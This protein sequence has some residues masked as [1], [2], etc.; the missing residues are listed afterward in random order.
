MLSRALASYSASHARSRHNADIYG[1]SFHFACLPKTLQADIVRTLK[2]EAE[3][4]DA[5]AAEDVDSKERNIMDIDASQDASIAVVISDS[6]EE[7]D[8]HTKTSRSATKPAEVKPGAA[9]KQTRKA[10]NGQTIRLYKKEEQITESLSIEQCPMCARPH[11]T[12]CFKCQHTQEPSEL[13]NAASKQPQDSQEAQAQQGQTGL[14][15]SDP[16]AAESNAS[17]ATSPPKTE[18]DVAAN[19]VMQG[20][21]QEEAENAVDSLLFRCNTCKRPAHYTCMPNL[22]ADDDDDDDDASQVNKSNASAGEL[23]LKLDEIALSYQ[24]E[25][26]CDDCLRWDAKPDVILAWRPLGH[27]DLTPEQIQAIPHPSP[28]DPLASVEYYVKW[29]NM[30]YRMAEW[31][32]HAFR[33]FCLAIH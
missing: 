29:Q 20:E 8:R 4:Q 16:A 30:S 3:E 24:H 19:K 15:Q 32:P 12:V 5:A 6:E 7:R 23:G 31:V 13:L 14:V 2:A 21:E 10:L 25:W 17:A 26:R 11:G 33:A 22:D 18:I 28:K 1:F 27:S 9:A